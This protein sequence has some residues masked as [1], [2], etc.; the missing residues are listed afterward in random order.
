MLQVM[1]INPYWVVVAQ[2]I[3]LIVALIIDFVGVQRKKNAMIAA[4]MEK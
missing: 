4:A 3:L 2:G 1:N